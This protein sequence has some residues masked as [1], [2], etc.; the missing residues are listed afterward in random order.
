MTEAAPA[1]APP[2]RAQRAASEVR[3]RWGCLAVLAVAQLMVVLDTTIMNIALPSAQ[4]DLGFATSDRQWVVTAY[5]ITFGSLLLVGGRISDRL[6]RRRALIIGLVGFAL[7]SALGG[8]A[9]SFEMLVGG[10]ALQGVFGALLA[11]TL[12]SFVATLFPSGRSRLRAFGLIGLVASS[13]AAV[14]L[15]LGGFLTEFLDWRWTMYVNVVFAAGAVLGARLLLPDVAPFPHRRVDVIGA[16]L[17]L[18][19]VGGLVFGFA[20]AEEQP[21]ISLAV[22]GP[23]LGGAMAMVAFVVW[24]R[25]A[26]SPLLPLRVVRD[27]D[28]GAAYLCRFTISVGN[29][30]VLFFMSFLLQRSLGLGPLLTGLA[31]APMVVGFFAGSRLVT[32]AMVGRLRFRSVSALGLLLVAASFAWLSRIEPDTGYWSGIAWPVLLFG[33]GQA[34]ATTAT[35][36][37]GTDRLDPDDMGVGSAMLNVTQQLGGA[38][39]TAVLSGVAALV[40]RTELRAGSATLAEATTRGITTAFLLAATLFVVSAVACGLLATGR[41]RPARAGQPSRP[42]RSRQPRRP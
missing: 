18:T 35:M 19:G 38:L 5:G 33:I 29:Y 11:P 34:I 6:G 32:T 40:T 21:W 37:V 12:L 1:S 15:I 7:A 22:L 3:R 28:R 24:Q 20:E 13:G 2:D 23:A 36:S 42:G 14:G 25:F 26:R 41:D 9:V 39:G 27:R 17:A 30:A 31:I 8:A 16:A 10:R 4:E